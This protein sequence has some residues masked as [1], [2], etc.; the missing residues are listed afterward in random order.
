[1][2]L[3]DPGATDGHFLDGE[4][5]DDEGWIDCITFSELEWFGEWLFVSFAA[6]LFII[7]FFVL[8]VGVIMQ[9]A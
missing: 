6:I 3:P 1:M 8:C 7:F 2:A 4:N 5:Y 9:F